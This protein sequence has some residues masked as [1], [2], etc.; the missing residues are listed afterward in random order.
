[1]KISR[2]LRTFQVAKSTTKTFDLSPNYRLMALSNS[3]LPETTALTTRRFSS[4][5]MAMKLN[6]T[7]EDLY[8][9]MRYY[10]KQAL[11]QKL[12]TLVMERSSGK[13]VSATIALDYNEEGLEPPRVEKGEVVSHLLERMAENFRAKHPYIEKGTV[14]HPF[15]GS[16]AEGHEGKGLLYWSLVQVLKTGQEHGFKYCVVEAT[17][18]ATTH[19]CVDK[20]GF[21]IDNELSLSQISEKWKD[22]QPHRVQFLVK[23]L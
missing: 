1:M 16:T 19:I 3:F 2:I 22:V 8:P 23:E 20:L 17:D 13:I 6:I 21:S 18:P 12:S 14:L 9:L 11:D 10:V 4:T 15:L 7:Y 5:D